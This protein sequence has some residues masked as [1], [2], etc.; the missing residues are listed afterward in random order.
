MPKTT[1]FCGHFCLFAGKNER[2][3]RT[4][5]LA[6]R[7]FER[8]EP[9]HAIT[10]FAPE[11]R[12]AAVALGFRSF[13]S[14]YFVMRSA[15]LG[16]VPPRVVEA[17]F[18][19]FAS[20]RV[21]KSLAGVWDIATPD[22]ALA[23]RQGG[24]VAALQRYGL[25]ADD[26]LRTAADLLARMARAASVDGRPLFAALSAVPWPDEP[27]AA[28]WHAA[29]LLREQRGDA[30]VAALVAAGITGRE[31]NVLH[32]AAG[33]TTRERV[34]ATRDYDDAEWAAVTAQL[35]ARGL[36]TADGELTAAGQELKDDIEYRTDAVSLPA[37]DV[38]SDHEVETLFQVL[39]PIAR[40]VI[41][42]GDYPAITPMTSQH[43]DLDDPSANLG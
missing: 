40:Q 12:E 21:A 23:A 24:A 3:A 6:R 18:Y 33:R 13:W 35:A 1:Q 15:P 26:N 27:V 8:F 37:L 4:P 39:T 16:P 20:Q 34:V 28:L 25:V 9:V 19:N 31:S 43:S 42:G 10:Y 29:T 22:Q 36:L 38:L 5:N 41:A 7:L 14:G 2:M 11:S 30:H 32:V 17:V